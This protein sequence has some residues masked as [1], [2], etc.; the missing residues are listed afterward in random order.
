MS[1]YFR[2][3]Q[4][5][6]L[7]DRSVYLFGLALGL[8]LLYYAETF[9]GARVRHT[10]LVLGLCLA[11]FYLGLFRD[12]LGPVEEKTGTYLRYLSDG[13]DRGYV[14][15]LRPVLFVA[16][17]AVSLVV[18]V[19]IDVHHVRLMEDGPIVGYRAA[20]YVIGAIIVY[21]CTDVTVRSFGKL[22]ASIVPLG[23]LY[24]YLG[25]YLPGALY[26]SGMGTEQL[27]RLTVL[28]MQGVYGFILQVGAT[29]V[30]IFL[31]LAGLTKA[32]G[33]LDYLMDVSKEVSKLFKSGIVHA[34]V[35]ASLAFGSITGASAANT[36]TTGSFTI[37]L[38]KNQGVDKG[39]AGGIET[40]ASIGGQ[41]VPPIMGI[42][43][44]IMA[45][46][47]GLSY[48][49]IIQAGLIPAVLFY[50]SVVVSVQLLIYKFGWQTTRD[51]GD[52]EYGVF[53]EILWYVAPFVVLIYFLAYQQYTPLTS[54]YYATLTLIG[55]VAVKYL[56]EQRASGVA[57]AVK[58]TANGLKVGSEEMAPLLVI[59]GAI[60]IIIAVFT[61]TGFAQR[62]NTLMISLAGGSVLLLLLLAMAVSL[63]FGLGMPAPAAYVLVASLAGAAMVR[64]GLQELVAHMFVF[65][66]AMYSSL[67][68]PVGPSTIVAAKIADAEYIDTAIKSSKL[69]LSGFV[70]P[71]IFVANDVLIYWAFP[72][73]ILVTFAILA[74]IVAFSMT[75]FAYDGSSRLSVVGRSVY[76]GLAVL[77]FFGTYLGL[78]GLTTQVGIGVAIIVLVLATSVMEVPG[79]SRMYA[80]YLTKP[81]PMTDSGN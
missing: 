53:L 65:Y 3:E 59:L 77:G 31:L 44:F 20:D 10:N 38:M 25:P 17:A 11:I 4:F 66:F 30:A 67:T 26:H 78:F 45:D 7:G 75:I 62:L 48:V 23:F 54:G 52:V 81:S 60:G 55:F 43:A 32:Y 51:V 69:A 50:F 63:I 47:L 21:L 2:R 80:Q 72:S 42:A 27:L 79:V 49:R 40:V 29:W 19:Y 18:M 14:R 64:F 37:P 9:Y 6:R 39:Y 58:D 5:Q 16:L 1:T 71:F 15:F 73:T 33:I 68:P 8:L 46:L 61:Q 24:G 41:L 28:G 12:A 34:A 70:I 22:M 13:L 76:G 74:G 57:N 36:A 35:L 56:I